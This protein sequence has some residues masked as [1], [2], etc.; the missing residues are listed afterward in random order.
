LTP[1][2]TPVC[3]FFPFFFLHLLSVIRMDQAVID[4]DIEYFG[5]YIAPDTVEVS[6]SWVC[7]RVF[8]RCCCYALAG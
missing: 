6:C 1:L 3:V 2:F 7:E 8:C 4:E 5:E